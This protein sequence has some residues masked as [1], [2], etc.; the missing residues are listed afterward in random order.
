M[1][2]ESTPDVEI[3]GIFQVASATHR[4]YDALRLTLQDQRGG[5]AP[6]E[7][8]LWHGTSWSQ[9]PKILKEGFNR[10]FAGRH[11]T[12][13]GNAT[14]FSTDPA[15]SHRFC[16]RRGGGKDGTKALIVAQV[17]IGNYCK[18]CP[19]DVEPP[20]MDTTT[21]DRYDS[22]VNSDENPFIFAIFR[23]FQA[24]P[25]FLVETKAKTGV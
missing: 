11:G 3:R 23:D 16:D 17:L 8:E 12:L 4:T 10:S 5:S 14:Y 2:A 19:S 25:L 6:L 9:I 24:L 18:G 1:L 13:L 22:T 7:K 20:I 21:G 15:Y